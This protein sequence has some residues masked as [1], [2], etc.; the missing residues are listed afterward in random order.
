MALNHEADDWA[1]RIEG[2]DGPRLYIELLKRVLTRYGF[3]SRYREFETRLDFR[4]RLIV[5]LNKYLRRRDVELVRRNRFNPQSRRLGKDWPP[6]A[7][8]MIGLARLDNLESCI[9]TI[10]AEGV[11][12]DFLEAGV[13]RG[14]AGIFMAGAL[15]ALGAQ[16]R[17]IWLADSFQGLPK[18]SGA[19]ESDVLGTP[20]WKFQELAVTEEEVTE[21]FKKYGLWRPECIRILR[22]WFRDSLPTAPVE[23]LALL[24]LDGD[25]YESTIVALEA[26]YPKLESG[27]FCIVDDYGEIPACAAAVTDYRERVGCSARMIAVDESCVYWRQT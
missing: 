8:T 10:L 5:A 21:N 22:G 4:G 1:L 20:F 18:P 7:E 24:R 16:G 26:L 9:R 11:E 17:R 27:G 2:E 13:W 23:K 14:G 19:Y 6:E 25:M 15:Q 3:E 12:G